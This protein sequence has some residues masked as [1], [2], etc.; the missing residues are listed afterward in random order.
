M[1]KEF[2]NDVPV[3]AEIRNSDAYKAISWKFSREGVKLLHMLEKSSTRIN[4]FITGTGHTSVKFFDVSRKI[5]RRK[6]FQ[7]E[8]RHSSVKERRTC[9]STFG[10]DFPL[11]RSLNPAL[12]LM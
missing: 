8:P 11:P 12:P 6:K 9:E 5:K 10:N 4:R 2:R 3:K 7:Y 1:E